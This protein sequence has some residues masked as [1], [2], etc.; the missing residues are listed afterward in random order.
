MVL[1]VSQVRFVDAKKKIDEIRELSFLAP[2][3]D[4]PIALDWNQAKWANLPISDLSS[5]PIDGVGFSGLPAAATKPKSY[6]AWEKEF[7]T[8]LA[9]TQS[10]DLMFSPSL[11]QFSRPGEKEPEFRIRMQLASR[12]LTDES[13]EK[14]KKKYAPKYAILDERIRKAEITRERE[15]DQAKRQKYQ[16]AASIGS[17]ILGA[18]AG[19]KSGSMV[20][21][22]ARELS[23]S[24]KEKQDVRFAEENLEALIDRRKKLDEEFQAEMRGAAAKADPLTEKLETVSVKPTKTNIATKLVALVWAAEP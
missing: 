11:A 17:S 1:G 13:M 3:V 4:G 24:E 19:R 6:A 21:K 7:E 12:E 14:L 15:K 20:S 5:E 9:S 23:R 16:S 2:L 18:M 22:T 8:W 10:L